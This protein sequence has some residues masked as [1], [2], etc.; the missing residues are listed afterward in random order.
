MPKIGQ[1]ISLTSSATIRC[2][3]FDLKMVKYSIYSGLEKLDKN[4]P[5]GLVRTAQ[6]WD[7]AA[8]DYLTSESCSLK[9]VIRTTQSWNAAA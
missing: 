5:A 1:N 8:L 6:S 3:Q 2:T 9:M 4:A 7:A